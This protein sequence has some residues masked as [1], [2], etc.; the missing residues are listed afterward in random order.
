MPEVRLQGKDLLQRRSR[1][2]SGGIIKLFCN[3]V[4]GGYSDV[5]VLQFLEL[6]T[7]FCNTVHLRKYKK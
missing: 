3:L 2:K 6:Y 1:R 5:Y 7:H 4:G